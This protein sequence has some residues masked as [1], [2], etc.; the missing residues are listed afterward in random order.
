M[1]TT[2]QAIY[3]DEGI[4]RLLSPIG[5][6]KGA[7]VEITVDAEEA[8]LV[9]PPAFNPSVTAE[10]TEAEVQARWEAIQSV[11]AVAV[12]HGRQENASRDHDKYLYGPDGAA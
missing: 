3:E 9:L 6:K 1:T 11:I 7:Q 4:L 8:A 2:L 10:L 5:L 12:P